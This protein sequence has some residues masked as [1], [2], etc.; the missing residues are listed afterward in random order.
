M[1]GFA[2]IITNVDTFSVEHLKDCFYQQFWIVYVG[3]HLEA[4]MVTLPLIIIVVAFMVVHLGALTV[5]TLNN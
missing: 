2:L 3:M 4:K 1:V 5:G